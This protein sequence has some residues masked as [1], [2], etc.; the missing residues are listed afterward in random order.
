MKKYDTTLV[1][2]SIVIISALVGALIA[3]LVV[4][5]SI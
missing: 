5:A 2:T 4:K 3:L 1:L